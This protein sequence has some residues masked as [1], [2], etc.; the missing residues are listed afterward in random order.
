L[1]PLKNQRHTQKDQ[2]DDCFLQWLG[3]EYGAIKTLRFIVVTSF[4]FA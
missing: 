4:S 2:E 1:S 3:R